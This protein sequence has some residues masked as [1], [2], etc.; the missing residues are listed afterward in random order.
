[1]IICKL[2][3]LSAATIDTTILVDV[4]DDCTN[5]VTRTPIIKPANGLVIRSDF[6]KSSL[7]YFPFKIFIIKLKY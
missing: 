5:T 4:D 7:A 1:M 2:R 3:L 6:R